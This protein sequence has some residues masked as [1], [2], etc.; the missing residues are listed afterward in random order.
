MAATASRG[1][2]GYLCSIFAEIPH[3]SWRAVRN[4]PKK[5]HLQSVFSTNECSVRDVF[6]PRPTSRER[7]SIT[8]GNASGN[9]PPEMEEI[10]NMHPPAT[11]V[12][13]EDPVAGKVRQVRA[14]AIAGALGRD[15]AASWQQT[16]NRVDAGGREPASRPPKPRSHSRLVGRLQHHKDDSRGR[17]H[18]TRAG[19]RERASHDLD[20]KVEGDA[21]VGGVYTAGAGGERI[22]TYSGS[23]ASSH[24]DRWDPA[25]RLL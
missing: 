15:D 4:V 25:V 17:E 9:P 8:N 20:D 13:A 1:T 24:A 5:C 21:G 23:A 18:V 2:I 7:G 10:D 12:D 16:T 19:G 6:P 11:A 3:R 14:S 22:R